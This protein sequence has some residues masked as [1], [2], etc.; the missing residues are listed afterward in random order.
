MR[1]FCCFLQSISENFDVKQAL[2][3]YTGKVT[4]RPGLSGTVPIFNDVPQKQI[5]VFPGRP[6]VPFLAWCPGFV[7]TLTTVLFH[8]ILILI[9]IVYIRK[10]LWRPELRPGPHWGSS[11][12]SPRPPSWTPRRLANVALAPYDSRLRRSSRIAVPKLYIHTY[13]HTY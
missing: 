10:N 13:I 5:T 12:R 1:A 9:C 8:R 7:P 4:I 6:F 3:Y 11:R 2:L